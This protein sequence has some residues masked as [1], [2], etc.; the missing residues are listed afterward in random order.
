MKDWVMTEDKC[1]FFKN[2]MADP[3]FRPKGWKQIVLF[4]LVTPATFL[5]A[6]LMMFIS[7]YDSLEKKDD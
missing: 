3:I 6:G 7:W 1:S 4:P 5:L 2:L